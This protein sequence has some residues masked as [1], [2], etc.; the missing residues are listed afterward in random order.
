[1]SEDRLSRKEE[2]LLMTAPLPVLSSGLRSRVLEAA[3]EACD[4]RKRGRRAIASALLAFGLVGSFTWFRPSSKGQAR[5]VACD[6]AQ[7]HDGRQEPS[8]A[9]E[10]APA[11]AG[12]SSR[13]DLLMSAMGDDWKVVEAEFRS[14]E[15]FTRRFQVKSQM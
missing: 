5:S 2:I 15:E 9:A 10:G 1:M 4:R 6:S 7:P 11:S 14:R 8:S 13:N 12:G 3:G